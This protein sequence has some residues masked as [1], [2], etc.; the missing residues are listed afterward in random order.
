MKHKMQGIKRFF[1]NIIQT[2]CLKFVHLVNSLGSGRDHPLPSLQIA[3]QRVW[4]AFRLPNNKNTNCSA[5]FLAAPAEDI[6]DLLL[7]QLIHGH[8]CLL[9]PNGRR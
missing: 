5:A 2:T 4:A 7:C 1:V 3:S 8:H 6:P 9:Q